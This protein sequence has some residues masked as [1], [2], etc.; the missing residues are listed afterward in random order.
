MNQDVVPSPVVQLARLRRYA[1]ILCDFGRMAPESSG[2]DRLLQLACV[3]AAR[4]VGIRH[5]KLMRHRPETGD[6][7][8]VAG[9]GWKP[10]VVGRV[11]VGTDLASPPGQTLQTRLPVIV[12]DLR[13]D[14]EFR[15][16]AVLR[17]HGIVAALNVPII[18]DGQVWGVL[19]ADSETPWHFGPDDTQFLSALANILGLALHSKMGMQ[20]AMAAAAAAARALAQEKMLLGELQH[21]SKNDLQLILALLVLQRRKLP[22]AEGR[23]IF[24]H[25]MDR[26][27]AIGVAHDQLAIGR[28][29]GLIELADYL[30]ALCGNLSQRREGVAI[31]TALERAE[32]PHARAVPLGLVV[33]ELVTNALKHAFPDGRS[34]T[35]RVEFRIPPG[36]EARLC[37]CDDGVGMGPPRPGS[38]GT[39]L[40]RRLVQQIGGRLEQLE[41]PEQPQGTG[42]RVLFPLV[43]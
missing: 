22:D 43:T 23:R 27:T 29:T 30:Q 5:T 34:G 21:R 8:I 15:S 24:G 19:E 28:G 16:S 18:V 14:P 33:N 37:V 26:V 9:V 39:E 10:G 36:G 17:E 38:S 4:G 41:Q 12:G 40:V 20:D 1:E 13:D 42:F 32:M 25:V 35:I 3:Q 11:S 31:E 7:L 2:I 6:L